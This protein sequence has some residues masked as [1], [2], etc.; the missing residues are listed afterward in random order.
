MF[1]SCNQVP[2][3]QKK[4][5]YKNIKNR[6]CGMVPL[7]SFSMQCFGVMDGASLFYLCN[8]WAL[9]S[10]LAFPSVRES[11][12]NYVHFDAVTGPHLFGHFPATL[13]KTRKKQE[14]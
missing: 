10:F 14:P 11:S 12:R 3:K 4:Y 6:I 1:L 5:K 2:K 13:A 9:I 7:L 8:R